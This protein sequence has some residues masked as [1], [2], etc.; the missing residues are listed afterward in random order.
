MSTL[1]VGIVVMVVGCFALKYAGLSVPER[2]LDHPTTKRAADLIP[3]ALLGALIAV[4]V[5]AHD[6]SLRVDARLLSLVVAAVLLTLRVP[7]LPMVLA[8]ALVAALV[9]LV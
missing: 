2:V 9:R 5:F 4:Q 8:A 1:W 7:F 3:V 6:G